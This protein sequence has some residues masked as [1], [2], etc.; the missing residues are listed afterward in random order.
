M[1]EFNPQL[2]FGARELK[3]VPPHFI[4]CST[5]VTDESLRWVK[6]K[7]SGRFSLSDKLNSEN[8]IF[9]NTITI[10]FEDPGE[11]VMY[12]LRWSGSK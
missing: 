4:K 8:F 2:W 3:F 9:D 5:T 12:E 10:A 6:N 1:K 11:A 7:L